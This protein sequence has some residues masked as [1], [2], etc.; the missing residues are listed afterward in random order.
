MSVVASSAYPDVERALQR[1]EAYIRELPENNALSQTPNATVFVDVNEFYVI[2]KAMRQL[3]SCKTAPQFISPNLQEQILD[4]Q[5]KYRECLNLAEDKG[6]IKPVAKQ[7]LLRSVLPN[8]SQQAEGQSNNNSIR[9]NAPRSGQHANRQSS[10]TDKGFFA[11]GQNKRPSVAPSKP[12]A[13]S[14]GLFASF[15]KLVSVGG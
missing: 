11:F 1:F 3:P 2:S 14:G 12:A 15:R 10:R 7:A 5:A 13:P 6:I 4:L 8:T 9:D